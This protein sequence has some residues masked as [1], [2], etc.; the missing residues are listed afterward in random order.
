MERKDRDKDIAFRA[1]AYRE[2]KTRL[3]AALA[4]FREL[5][6]IDLT[7]DIDESGRHMGQ[8]PY[9]KLTAERLAWVTAKIEGDVWDASDAVAEISDA[10]AGDADVISIDRKAS[11]CRVEA[12]ALRLVIEPYRPVLAKR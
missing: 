10:L 3:T 9:V 5:T 8:A 11:P 7:G 1:A 2:G 12:P 6:G 4:G